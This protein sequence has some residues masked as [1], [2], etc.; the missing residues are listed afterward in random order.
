[1]VFYIIGAVSVQK[2]SKN[3][4]GLSDKQIRSDIWTRWTNMSPDTIVR[5]KGGKML[6]KVVG[7]CGRMG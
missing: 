4:I 7:G 1:M 2:S 5:N 3:H 6:D